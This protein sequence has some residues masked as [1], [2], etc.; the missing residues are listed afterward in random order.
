AKPLTLYGN[1]DVR[2]VDLDFRV[3]GRID[4]LL[5]DEGER[6]R[7]G[8][9]LAALNAASIEARVNEASAQ[10]EQARAQLEKLQVGN[11]RQDIGQAR[12]RV[13]AAAAIARN[14]ERDYRRRSL[15][16]EPGAISRNLW[17]QTITD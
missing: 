6:V 4:R 11:R 12:A 15:L 17:D 13:A 16:V 10:V 9:L 3:G 8:Q 2:T 7:A 1:V 5:A 14:A